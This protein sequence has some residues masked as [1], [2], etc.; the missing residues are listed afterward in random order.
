MYMARDSKRIFADILANSKNSKGTWRAINLLTNKHPPANISTTTGIFPDDL[1]HFCSVASKVIKTEISPSNEVT[2]LEQYCTE[3]SSHKASTLPF[4]TVRGVYKSVCH[5]KQ[6]NTKGTDCVSWHFLLLKLLHIYIYIYYNLCIDKNAFSQAF[7][8]AKVIPLFTSG[9]KS[10]PSNF[11][12]I[13]ILPILSQ[14][15]EKHTNQHFIEHFLV[16]DLFCQKQS[17]FRPN[18]SCPTALTE[19][20]DTWLSEININQVCGALLIDFAKDF[21]VINHDLLLRNLTLYGLSAN[22]LSLIC[23]FL[24]SRLQKD[25]L[26]EKQSDFKTVLFGV[27]LGSVL[28]PLLFSIYKNDLPLHVPSAKCGMLADDTTIHASGQD[29]PAI[30]FVLQ[31]C[32]SDVVEWTHLN[33]VP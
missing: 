29:V 25:S 13:S 30:T 5:L 23:S 14:P 19:L 15:I 7:K 31:S 3:T 33:H 18:H 21:D 16:N 11:R 24:N 28:G 9:D 2:V 12:P 8:E 1:N 22:T 32:I 10:D 4:M 20:I 17:G 27:P 26:K 6:S